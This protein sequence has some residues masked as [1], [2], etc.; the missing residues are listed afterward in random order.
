MADT[1]LNSIILIG[2]KHSGKSTMGKLLAQ[3]IQ[4]VFY[5]TDDVIQEMT[6]L[7]PRELYSSKGPC[8]FMLAEEEACKKIIT[9]IQGKP[10]V[11]ATGGGICDNA[12]ALNELQTIGNFVFLKLN[13]EYSIKRIEDKIQIDPAGKMTNLPLGL[14]LL[15]GIKKPMIKQKPHGILLYIKISLFSN[16]PHYLYINSRFHLLHLLVYPFESATLD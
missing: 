11:I 2:L 10:S 16:S 7:S 13:M 8:A 3:K 5:D 15:I 14:V 4:A 1:P 12:P 6:G 9:T